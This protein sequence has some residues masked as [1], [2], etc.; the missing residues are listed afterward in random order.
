MKS[1]NLQVVFSVVLI[2]VAAVSMVSYLGDTTATAKPSYSFTLNVAGKAYDPHSHEWVKVSLYLTGTE[3]G[4]LSMEIDLYVKGGD[5]NVQN[6][7]TFPVSQGCGEIVY[8]HC[9]YIALFIKLT[10]KYYGG[11]TALWCLSGR[12]GGKLYGKILCV[13]LYSDYIVI[14]HSGKVLKDLWL[15]G[16]LT[17]VH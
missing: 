2:L 13:A 17:P 4:K 16:T 5:V 6:F 15:T 10:S 7:G 9:H 1:R 8:H 12:T 11:N 14:P 3:Y